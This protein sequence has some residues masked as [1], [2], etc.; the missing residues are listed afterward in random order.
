MRTVRAGAAA[1]SAREPREWFVVRGSWFLVGWERGGWPPV[2]WGSWFLVPGSAR[3]TNQKPETRNHTMEESRMS[4]TPTVPPR[5]LA[6]VQHALATLDAWNAAVC[7]ARRMEQ[8]AHQPGRY[9]YD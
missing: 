8:I 6:R 1:N 4:P 2:V 5:V 3:P 9:E 7:Q